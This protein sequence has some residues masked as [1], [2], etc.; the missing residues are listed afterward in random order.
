LADKSSQQE[1]AGNDLLKKVHQIGHGLE[2]GDEVLDKASE[3]LDDYRDDFNVCGDCFPAA[4]VHIASRLEDEPR[5][6]KM[7]TEQLRSR[8][9]LFSSTDDRLEEKLREKVK[10]LKKKDDI[11]E[12]LDPVKSKQHL[13]YI[14]GQLQVEVSESVKGRA[15]AYCDVVESRPGVARSKAA[16][17]G[18]CL[19]AAM[20]E[21]GGN[22]SV[23]HTQLAEITGMNKK[24]FENN[25]DY[26]REEDVLPST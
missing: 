25:L 22:P 7:I 26:L 19:K 15:E 21:N 18:A 2:L 6:Q 9:N 13:R 1:E 14:I 12:Q 5:T 10:K 17:A 11:F 16:I 23:T 20:Q 3:L 8:N 4:A 24:T